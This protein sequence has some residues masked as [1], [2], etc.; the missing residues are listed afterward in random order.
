MA[1]RLPK[2]TAP[3]DAGDHLVYTTDFRRVYATV[4]AGWLRLLEDPL[5]MDFTLRT[6]WSSLV[7]RTDNP[8]FGGATARPVTGRA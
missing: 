4:I 8:L 1:I 2:V 3:V 7:D 5:T 6:R